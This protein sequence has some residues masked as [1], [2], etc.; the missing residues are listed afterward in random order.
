MVWMGRLQKHPSIERVYGPDLMLNLCQHSVANGF[1]HFLFGGVPGVAEELRD[2]LYLRFPGLKV[3]GTYT[4]PFRRMNDKELGDLQQMVR[5]SQPDFFW[6]GLS[7]P[8]AGAFHGSIFIGLARGKDSY[9][10]RRGL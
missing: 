4:P 6:V 10:S 8:E 1:K 9:R 3:V 7:T 5:A 2:N